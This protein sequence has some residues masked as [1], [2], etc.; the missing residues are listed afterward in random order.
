VKKRAR[1]VLA[2][3]SCVGGLQGCASLD[4]TIVDPVEWWAL[5]GWG[6]SVTITLYDNNC[7][8]PLRDIKFKRDEEIKVVSCGDGQGQADVRFRR[9]VNAARQV[10]WSPD[11]VVSTNQRTIVR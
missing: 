1:N 4:T 2:L 8:R 7:G 6:S 3:L 9:E 5:N 11:T 10:P